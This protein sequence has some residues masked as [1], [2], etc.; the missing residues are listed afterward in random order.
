MQLSKPQ[1]AQKHQQEKE[2]FQ[3]LAIK[4]IRW[5]LGLHDK[6]DKIS[7]SEWVLYK[8]YQLSAIDKH[9]DVKQLKQRLSQT[10]EEITKKGGFC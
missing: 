8:K 1:A 7:S 3:A 9:T 5:R 6:K 4:V 10:F 2:K